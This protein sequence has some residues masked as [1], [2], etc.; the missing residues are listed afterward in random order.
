MKQFILTPAA[1]K[2][3]IGKGLAAHPAVQTV[4]NSGT[5]VIVAGTTNGYVAEE[6]LAAV[7]AEAPFSRNRFFRG[8]T[9]APNRPTVDAERPLGEQSFPGD[10][11]LENGVWKPGLTIFDVAEKLRS[12][13]MILKG[14]NAL[15]VA[16]RQ[17][18]VLVGHPQGGTIFAALQAAVGRRTQ[19][20]L[21]V[22]LEKRVCEDLHVLAQKVNLPE[23]QGP[24]LLPVSGTVFT[25]LDAIATLTGAQA[26]LMAA[27]G[28]QGAEGAVWL[29]I[30]GTAE[31][32]IAAEKLL[33]AA[34]SEP[35]FAEGF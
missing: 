22:G 17:A 14:A 27:G 34:A 4:L 30:E 2:R 32:T 18:A 26:F 25:E 6:I 5:L 3:L 35:P 15:D 20:F 1:S 21:P 12:G 19:L 29:G 31:Q 16:R 7:N 24:R 28:V 10:V 23:A 9:V 8:V 33:K 13:D 11:V